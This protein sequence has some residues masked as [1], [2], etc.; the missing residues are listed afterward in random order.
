MTKAKLVWGLNSLEKIKLSKVITDL[1]MRE[2]VGVFSA[3]IKRSHSKQKLYQM[4]RNGSNG[5]PWY[6]HGILS[7]SVLLNCKP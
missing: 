3:K 1:R 4:K 2:Q 6:K 5:L 7:S